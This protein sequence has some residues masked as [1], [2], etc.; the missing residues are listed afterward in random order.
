VFLKNTGTE[1]KRYIKFVFFFLLITL[2]LSFSLFSSSA[3]ST[4]LP[5]LALFSSLS[6]KVIFPL[7]RLVLFHI[8][9]FLIS[10]IFFFYP[11]LSPFSPYHPLP[12][13][14]F[15]LLHMLLLF[16]FASLLR[17]HSSLVILLR[18]NISLLI[19]PFSD[20]SPHITVQSRS[21]FH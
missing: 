4:S 3:C 6:F 12:F 2:Q 18:P 1:M 5:F 10:S 11:S 16:L 14:L 13:L 21:A 20:A 17:F 9:V 7:F 19:F 15:C 8:F